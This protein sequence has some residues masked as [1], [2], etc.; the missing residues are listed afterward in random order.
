MTYRGNIYGG[1]AGNI[2]GGANALGSGGGGGLFFGT[3]TT[4][5][6]LTTTLGDPIGFYGV[7]PLLAVRNLTTLP[8][9]LAAASYVSGAFDPQFFNQQVYSPDQK[10]VTVS[11]VVPCNYS[12]NVDGNGWSY[13]IVFRD[14]GAFEVFALVWTLAASY[15]FV[16]ALTAFQVGAGGAVEAAGPTELQLFIDS[17]SPAPPPCSGGLPLPFTFI[18]QATLTRGTYAPADRSG[19]LQAWVLKP[20]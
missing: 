14:D 3:V 20:P 5:S 2:Y 19:L 16:P 15:Q 6:T 9:V 4:S 18:S 8:T 7:A 1:G 11:G 17:S 12:V 10:F 13:L